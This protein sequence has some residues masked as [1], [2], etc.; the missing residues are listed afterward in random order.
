MR[1]VKKKYIGRVKKG[2]LSRC[3]TCKEKGYT[4]K[5]LVQSK[6]NHSISP[7]D[8]SI[9]RFY[10]ETKKIICRECKGTEV[11]LWIDRIIRKE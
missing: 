11:I 1:K 7:G 6:Y 5:V 4:D 8:K 10:Y 3:P 9:A 2:L